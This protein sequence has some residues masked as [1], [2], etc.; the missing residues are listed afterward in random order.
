MLDC[1]SIMEANPN[2]VLATK[3]GG[4]VRTRVFQF[5]YAVDD[6]PYFCTGASKQ[7][8]AQMKA[9]PAVSFCTFP[10]DFAPVICISGKAVFVEDLALKERALK[11]NPPIAALYHSA[12]SPE[13]QLFYI[14]PEEMETFTFEDGTQIYKQPV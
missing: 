8:Y 4:G 6:K 2:G 1:F 10:A 9:D 5:L 12:A 13:F 14:E 7:V 11:E 3:R